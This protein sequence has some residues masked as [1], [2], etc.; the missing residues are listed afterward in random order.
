LKKEK[1]LLQE[2]DI[3]DVLYEQNQLSDDEKLM[4]ENIKEEFEGIWSHEETK[5]WQESRDR[6]IVEGD[7]NTTYFLAVANQRR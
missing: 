3:L 5:V 2:F 4:M 7:H 1:T 6:K